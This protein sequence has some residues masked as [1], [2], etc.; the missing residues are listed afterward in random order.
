MAIETTYTALCAK[1][2]G[3]LDRVTDDRE[4]V[5]ARR[6]PPPRRPACRPDGDGALAALAEE[7]RAPAR[8]S[9]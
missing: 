6:G 1:L 9:A 8:V 4:V 5:I 7:R 3:F 2:A